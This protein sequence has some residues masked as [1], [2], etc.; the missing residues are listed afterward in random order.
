MILCCNDVGLFAIGTD[1]LIPQHLQTVTLIMQHKP[2]ERWTN[3]AS[4]AKKCQTQAWLKT[5]YWQRMTSN[6]V[7]AGRPGVPAPV[8]TVKIRLSL[9]AHNSG[10]CR[11]V[12]ID[13]MFVLLLS[14]AIQI[15]AIS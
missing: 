9:P 12:C 2:I 3:M 14:P 1:M 11:F 7:H 13:I 6:H 5:R 4:I 8:M 15:A 10:S